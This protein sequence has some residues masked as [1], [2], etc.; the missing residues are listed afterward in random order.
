M[1]GDF[2]CPLRFSFTSLHPDWMLL[3][4]FT[5]TH[6]TITVT[7]ALLFVPKVL[8]VGWRHCKWTLMTTLAFQDGTGRRLRLS[9]KDA[10]ICP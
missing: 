5:H 2:F 8:T 10:H 4:S 7:L 3:L 1:C 6:V 9:E